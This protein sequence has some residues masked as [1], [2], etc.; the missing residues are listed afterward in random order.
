MCG[1]A[2]PLPVFWPEVEDYVGFNMPSLFAA[3]SPSGS[4][5]TVTGMSYAEV[6]LTLNLHCPQNLLN[7]PQWILGAIDGQ[8]GQFG[9][10]KSFLSAVSDGRVPLLFVNGG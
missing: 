8:R 5:V 9:L 3:L 6:Y 2:S 4:A 1:R 10:N 7:E